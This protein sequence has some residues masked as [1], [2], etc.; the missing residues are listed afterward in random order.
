MISGTVNTLDKGAITGNRVIVE[1]NPDVLS[2]SDKERS[3]NAINPTKKKRYGTIK[4]RT[5]ENGSNQR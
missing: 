3:P 2:R 5:C 4:G 1:I